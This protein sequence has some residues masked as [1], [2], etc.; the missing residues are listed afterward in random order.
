VKEKVL[1]I[2]SNTLKREEIAT[3]EMKLRVL[4]RPRDE[5]S[6]LLC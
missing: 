1:K 4:G 5:E 6:F 2:F 3:L